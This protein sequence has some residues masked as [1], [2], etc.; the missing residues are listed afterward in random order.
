MDSVRYRERRRQKKEIITRPSSIRERTS[1]STNFFHSLSLAFRT[2]QSFFV[3]MAQS[4]VPF[5]AFASYFAFPHNFYSFLL[6]VVKYTFSVVASHPLIT[7]AWSQQNFPYEKYFLFAC[8]TYF[9]PLFFSSC[10]SC[11]ARSF[12]CPTITSG[13]WIVGGFECGVGM[14]G[15]CVHTLFHRAIILSF[16]RFR[17]DIS[18]RQSRDWT[19]WI[20]DVH[21]GVRDRYE[22][23]TMEWEACGLLN[24]CG[25]HMIIAATAAD[26]DKPKRK[27]DEIYIFCPSSFLS[28]FFLLL[29]LLSP[30]EQSS[31][32]RKESATFNF[33]N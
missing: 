8:H 7:L 5:F 30:P 23:G 3:F 12:V 22:S 21:T 19:I 31:F 29:L 10:C 4:L 33:W 17:V 9:S 27:V 32:E 24:K 18:E 14:M 25:R 16:F 13:C 28:S 26:E 20:G 1:A 15:K 6:R 11:A 2:T